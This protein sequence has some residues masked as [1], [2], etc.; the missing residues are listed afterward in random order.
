MASRRRPFSSLF[1]TFATAF[2]AVMVAAVLLQGWVVINVVDRL[3]D[4][5]VTER[6]NT[7]IVGD[8]TTA[9]PPADGTTTG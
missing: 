8:G 5:R 4:E 2:L 9:E 7:L 6:A 3:T 1:W